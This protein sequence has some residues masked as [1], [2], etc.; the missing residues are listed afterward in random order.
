MNITRIQT[1]GKAVDTGPYMHLMVKR[2]YRDMAPYAHLPFNEMFRRIKL[3]PYR[4][5]PP[6]TETLMRPKFTM[7]RKGYGGDC[8]DKAIAMA[9][10]AVL[11]SLPYRFVAVRK[12][13]K[14]QLHHV[15][16]EVMINGDWLTA[17]CTYPHNVLGREHDNYV[18]RVLI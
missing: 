7:E 17:D 9:S 15:F 16:T 18:E 2:Y 4:Y 6:T 1:S 12:A 11:N 5:D 13:G 3:I 10:W 8:D 14:P